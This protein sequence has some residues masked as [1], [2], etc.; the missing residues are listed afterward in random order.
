MKDQLPFPAGITRVNDPGN[1]A[2]LEQV[3]QHT[4]L[5]LGPIHR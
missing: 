3:Q 1:I 5:L 2:A 4:E